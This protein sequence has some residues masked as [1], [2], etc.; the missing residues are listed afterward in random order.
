MKRRAWPFFLALLSLAILGSYLVYT[1]YLFRAIREEA[2]V[3]SRM[4]AHV[5]EG[6]N[7]AE[8]A[9]ETEALRALQLEIRRLGVPIVV[10]DAAGQ[11]IAAANLP[12]EADPMDPRDHGRILELVERL[13][14]RNPPISGPAGT[15][16]Y[17]PPPVVAWLRWVPWLQVGGALLVLLLAGGMVQVSLRAERERLWAAMA[18][19]L[20]HQMGTPLSSLSGWVEVLGLAPEERHRL[21][22]EAQIAGEI[23][24]DV[25]RLERV[26]RRFELIGK[27]PRLKP[28]AVADVLRELESYI[29]PRLPRRGRDT[30]LTTRVE[31]GLPAVRANRV[32]LVWALENIVKNAL[33]ALAGR[34]GRIRL[35]AVRGDGGGVRILI[36]D[37][38]PGVPPELRGRI[39][40]AGVTTKPGGWGVGLSLSRRIV[41]DLHGGR[42]EV[43][44]RRGGGTLFIVALEAALAEEAEQVQPRERGD[45]SNLAVET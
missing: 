40:E 34:P 2:A 42:I 26:S 21:A 43:R 13:D 10:L 44:P 19:E 38:G 4:Y 41:R 37:S 9:S 1:E 5:Q 27:K 35:A 12:F 22:D 11:P 3:H 7:S 32:L 14:R 23:G 28:V 36:A 39:F 31:T 20:A 45:R 18:R 30:I 17:G 24:R 15:I 25:E 33:D 8:P 6:L 29:R 16:H